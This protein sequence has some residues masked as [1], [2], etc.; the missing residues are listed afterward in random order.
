M[1]VCAK[2]RQSE[3]KGVQRYCRA[4]R[5]AYNRDWRRTAQHRLPEKA[6]RIVANALM[7]SGDWAAAELVQNLRME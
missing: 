7:K 3:L 6:K 5:A 4:C 1:P 2:C